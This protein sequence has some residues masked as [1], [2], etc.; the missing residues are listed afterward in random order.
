MLENI[1]NI[2]SRPLPDL[3]SYTHNVPALVEG[4]REASPESP[5]P[6]SR[7]SVKRYS[8]LSSFILRIFCFL[9]PQKPKHNNTLSVQP[10]HT[11]CNLCPTSMQP[12]N[13]ITTHKKPPSNAV[14]NHYGA[15]KKSHMASK[16]WEKNKMS[17]LKSTATTNQQLQWRR[18]QFITAEQ[19]T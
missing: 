13:T 8:F 17:L 15:R 16:T 10:P 14:I 6:W 2:Q 4:S 5:W 12:P 19:N 9:H 11:T 1:K 3:K 18:I 7:S